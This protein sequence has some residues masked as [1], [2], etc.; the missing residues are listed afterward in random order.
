MQ[1]IIEATQPRAR[2]SLYDPTQEGL[3]YPVR[4]EFTSHAEERR[5]RQEHLV[6]ACRAFALHQL[7]FGF[8]GHLTVRDPE[9]PE[10]Y[11]TNPM[12]V[13][14]LLPAAA[15][16]RRQ[17]PSTCAGAAGQGLL[18]PRERGQRLHRLAAFPGPLRP[19]VRHAAGHVQLRAA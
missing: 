1:D 9:R 7:D 6:A 15:G 12:C 17:R 16:N 14:S 2:R 4:P 5:Y 11:W 3:V 18:Q 13:H 10:L 8:A 19:A